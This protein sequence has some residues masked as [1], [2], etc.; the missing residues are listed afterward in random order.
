MSH[1]SWA[2]KVEMLRQITIDCRAVKDVAHDHSLKPNVLSQLLHRA[3]KDKNYV[4][5]M[6]EKQEEHAHHRKLVVE[7]VIKLN[8][9]GDQIASIR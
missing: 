4:S 2:E 8:T 5:M 6:L 7:A 3:K 9:D 1:Y